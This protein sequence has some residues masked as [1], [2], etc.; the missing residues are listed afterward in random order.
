MVSADRWIGAGPKG[1]C[2]MGDVTS[3]SVWLRYPANRVVNIGCDL[4]FSKKFPAESQELGPVGEG[5]PQRLDTPPTMVLTLT[6][7]PGSEP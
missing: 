1:H 7:M 6:P 2:L 4:L 5:R 3:V